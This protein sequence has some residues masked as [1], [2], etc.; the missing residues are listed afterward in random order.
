M[1]MNA[2]LY[3]HGFRGF[4]TSNLFLN[5]QQWRKSSFIDENNGSLLA[6]QIYDHLSLP[7]FP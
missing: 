4:L 7:Y 1:M 6:G 5:C 2:V 3:I